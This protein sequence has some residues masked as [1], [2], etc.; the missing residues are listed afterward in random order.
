[1]PEPMATVA[2]HG[3][4]VTVPADWSLVGV[5]GD[6]KKGYLRIDSPIASALEVR[7]SAAQGKAPDLMV[8]GR[9]FLSNLEKSCRKNKTKFDKKIRPDADDPD[10]VVF[11][12]RADRVGQGFLRY[13]GKCDRVII[14]QMLMD[15]EEKVSHL[16]PTILASLRDHR[17]DDRTDWGLYGLEFSVP[18]GYRIDKQSLMSGY[19]SLS[20]KHRASTLVVERWALASTLLSSDSMEQWYR[21]DVV[22]DIKGYRVQIAEE[23]IHGHAG[24]RIEG[25]RGGIRQAVRALVYSLTLH[26]HPAFL[27]GYAWYCRESN[28]LFAVR[29]THTEG[30]NTADVVRDSITCHTRSHT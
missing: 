7:W 14:A 17:E 19:L 6:E 28:R 25:R 30:S 24:L 26:P 11:S 12:W 22:P 4:S 2:W 18:R 23:V 10:T 27:T 21:K 9:E 15:R 1:M 8:K 13:C 20:F 16:I 3:V 5:S 29:A